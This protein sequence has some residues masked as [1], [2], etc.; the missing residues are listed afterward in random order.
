[1]SMLTATP[2]PSQALR[3]L[4]LKLLIQLDELAG[5]ATS[6]RPDGVKARMSACV[7]ESIA[8]TRRQIAE[9]Q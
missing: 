2:R 8:D 7:E 3:N 6:A 1:M 9:V 5:I 4:R